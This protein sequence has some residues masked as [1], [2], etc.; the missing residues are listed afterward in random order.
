MNTKPQPPPIIGDDGELLRD[1]PSVKRIPYTIPIR[2]AGLSPT[3]RLY[4]RRFPWRRLRSY[5]AAAGFLVVVVLFYSQFFQTITPHNFSTSQ[6]AATTRSA[7]T[8]KPIITPATSRQIERSS[9]VTFEMAQTVLDVRW[10]RDD[11]QLGALTADGLVIWN[12]VS[13]H[14]VIIPNTTTIAAFDWSPDGEQ[15][16]IG[17]Q[18][19]IVRVWATSGQPVATLVKRDFIPETIWKLDWSPSGEMIA[20]RY[21]DQRTLSIFSVETNEEIY[22][23]EFA[24]PLV[25]LDW[26]LAG[27]RLLLV[28]ES[29]LFQWQGGNIVPFALQSVGP[30]WTQAD[31]DGALALVGHTALNGELAAVVMRFNL[32]SGEP[33]WAKSVA[34]IKTSAHLRKPIEVKWATGKPL[35]AVFTEGDQTVS[36]WDGQTGAQLDTFA[37]PAGE[38][39][40][41]I[42]WSPDGQYLA[43]GSASQVVIVRW[44][45]K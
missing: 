10:S 38:V 1:D 7:P 26:F 12:D 18:D 35:L 27:N 4:E 19:G 5:S 23:H 16:V 9:V 30:T 31:V 3:P 33:V 28:M 17:G 37:Q 29:R 41:S 42:D 11:G 6:T 21:G 36:I 2:A 13:G 14:Q 8:L 25:D 34:G 40:T 32:L 20:V 15:V 24:E 45:L 39:I 44:E 43:V 22:R